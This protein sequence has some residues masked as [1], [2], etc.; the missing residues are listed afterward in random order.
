MRSISASTSAISFRAAGESATLGCSAHTA[1]QP[2]VASMVMAA[3]AIQA[4]I[5]LDLVSRNIIPKMSP[6]QS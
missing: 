2:S 4:F 6:I 1:A 3:A 5:R